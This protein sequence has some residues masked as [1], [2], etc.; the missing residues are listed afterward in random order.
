MDRLT[1]E[2]RRKNMKSVK[3]HGS[4]IE[5]MLAKELWS[6]GLRYRKNDK[7][8]FGKPD[9]SFKKYK[10]AIFVDGEFWHGKDWKRRK[11][12]HKSNIDF[13]FKK[14]ERNI[15]RDREV[16]LYLK[17]NGW[18]VLRFWG[19]DI[20]KNLRN[21]TNKIIDTINEARRKNNNR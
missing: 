15:N 2:Q 9:L 13:W 10:I 12:D 17:K 16:N 11:Y 8:I 7:T 20:S 6:A 19:K 4:K 3:G 18:K 1:Q 14:I 21:C 5:K